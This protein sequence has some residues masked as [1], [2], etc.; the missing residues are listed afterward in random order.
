VSAFANLHILTIRDG[1]V[2]VHHFWLLA[3]LAY[4]IFSAVKP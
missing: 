1:E 3:V 4:V 2:Y